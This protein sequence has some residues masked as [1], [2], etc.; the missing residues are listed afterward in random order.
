MLVSKIFFVSFFLVLVASIN[1]R[2]FF[3]FDFST[4]SS[5]EKLFSNAVFIHLNGIRKK[6]MKKNVYECLIRF[7]KNK[8]KKKKQKNK[9]TKNKK[10]TKI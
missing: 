7:L 5:E 2:K 1:F 8:T 4:K 3:F 6:K 9:K 10:T